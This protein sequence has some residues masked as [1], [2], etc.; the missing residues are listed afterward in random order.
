MRKA[1]GEKGIQSPSG[2]VRG[3]M[4]SST[5][6][7]ISDARAKTANRWRSMTKTEFVEW[8]TVLYNKGTLYRKHGL[9]GNVVTALKCRNETYDEY[10]ILVERPTT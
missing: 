5:K 10:R 2:Y 7:A 4:K 8:L 3:P 6:H 1:R 9:G